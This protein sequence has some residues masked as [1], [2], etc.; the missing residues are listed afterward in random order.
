[1]N[2]TGQL[3]IA[4]P[5]IRQNFWQKSVILITENHARGSMGVIVN[6]RTKLSVREFSKQV[7]E[8][9]NIPGHMYGGGPVNMQ[10]LT[11]LHTSEWAC[12]NT[13]KINDEISLS[14]H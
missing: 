10:A 1:M 6:K 8:E 9:C 12:E 4:P 2:L 7:Y 11:L 13:M 5:N 14:S 3:I